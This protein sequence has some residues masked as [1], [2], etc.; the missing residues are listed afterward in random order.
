MTTSRVFGWDLL[1]GLCALTVA[2]YHLMLW[3]DVAELPALGTYGVYLFFVLSGA[4]LAYNYP[5]Q[6]LSTLRDAASFIFARWM[7]LAPLY[8]LLCPV[9]IGM[10]ALH[11]GHV[12]DRLAQRMALNVTF[13]FGVYD[14]LVWALL[15][16][17]WSLG[18]EF[19]Y[20]FFFPVAVRIVRDWRQ[21]AAA[22][23]ALAITQALWIHFTIGADGW[24]D[25]VVAYHQAPAFGAYFFGGCMIGHRARSNSR[26]WPMV[27]GFG[28]WIAMGLLLGVLM[29]E[30]PG[31]DLLGWRGA[32][33]FAACFGVVH[34]SGRID[35]RGRMAVVAGWLGDV[36]YG[37]Y[38]LHPMVIW[39]VLW[40]V[41]PDAPELP[42][43]ERVALIVAV[44]VVTCIAAAC[45]ERWFERPLRGWARSTSM[46]RASRRSPAL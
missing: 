23:L 4:S 21:A 14:P 6:R 44:L 31:D 15:I 32:V 19:V 2:A 38:L 1:R 43:A 29:P 25:A 3:L 34:A 27:A 8:L 11:T 35:V 30:Q 9:F 16:G 33:L 42:V 18:I 46:P 7:R 45:S 41:L 37:F 26:S 36:T 13:A 39:T 24:S 28:A 10:L 5:A 22:F 20:Y 40:F 12:A 17:G